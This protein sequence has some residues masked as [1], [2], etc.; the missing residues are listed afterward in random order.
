MS[1]KNRFFCL[2]LNVGAFT[3]VFKDNKLIRSYKTVEIKVFLTFVNIFRRF[4]VDGRIWFWTGSICTNNYRYD[5]GSGSRSDPKTRE[6]KKKDEYKV[7][8]Y[9]IIEVQHNFK[10]FL[11][12]SR[13]IEVSRSG[14]SI[15]QFRV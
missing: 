11:S 9:H 7:Y 12:F 3:S 8:R 13:E 15:S 14:R 1:T 2:L 6:S 5:S 10:V 4:F